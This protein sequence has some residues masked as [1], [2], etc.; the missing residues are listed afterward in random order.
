MIATLTVCVHVSMEFIGACGV[1]LHLA[2]CQR[3][4]RDAERTIESLREK[5]QL[6]RQDKRPPMGASGVPD[7]AGSPG[8][9]YD[10]ETEGAAAAAAVRRRRVYRGHSVAFGVP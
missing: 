3:E 6:A 4:L 2:D 5:L 7:R 9:G 1:T 10:D 8:T